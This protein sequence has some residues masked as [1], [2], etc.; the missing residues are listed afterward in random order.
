MHQAT[1]PPAGVASLL[2][3]RRGTVCHI[4]VILIEMDVSWSEMPLLPLWQNMHA[5]LSPRSCAHSGRHSQFTKHRPALMPLQSRHRPRVRVYARRSSSC[6]R[7]PCGLALSRR[8]PQRLVGG[9]TQRGG[10]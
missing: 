1:I 4:S 7:C 2:S 5:Q 10:V 9:K 6:S 8:L 3:A